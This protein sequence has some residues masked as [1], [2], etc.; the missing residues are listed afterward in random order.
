[1]RPLLNGFM[2][3]IYLPFSTCTTCSIYAVAPPPPLFGGD[4]KRRKTDNNFLY[5]YDPNDALDIF[6]SDDARLPALN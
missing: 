1:V 2:Q 4:T 3:P 6:F 5:D